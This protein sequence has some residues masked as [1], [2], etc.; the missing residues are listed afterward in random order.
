MAKS[1][2]SKKP[3]CDGKRVFIEVTGGDL[4]ETSQLFAFFDSSDKG[5]VDAIKPIE[6]LDLYNKKSIFSWDWCKQTAARNVQLVVKSEGEDILLPL[7]DEIQ[8]LTRKD[9]VQDYQLSAIVPLV[10][11]STDQSQPQ[12]APVRNGYIYIYY[13]EQIWRELEVSNNEGALTFKDVNLNTYRDVSNGL[14]TDKDRQATGLPLDAIFIPTRAKNTELTVKIAYSENAWSGSHINYIEANRSFCTERFSTIRQKKLITAKDLPEVRHRQPGIEWH[15][16]KPSF[17]NQDLTGKKVIDEEKNTQQCEAEL[18]DSPKAINDLVKNTSQREYGL[19]SRALYDILSRK[20]KASTLDIK[21]AS[22]CLASAKAHHYLGYVL[23]D[24]IFEVRHCL[25]QI[26]A[27]KEYL[28]LLLLDIEAQPYFRA[29][30]AVN[31]TVT[32]PKRSDG[33]GNYYHEFFDSMDNSPSGVFNRTL[34]TTEREL[35]RKD[36]EAIQHRLMNLLNSPHFQA[37][38]RGITSLDKLNGAGGLILGYQAINL[39]GTMIDK[40]DPHQMVPHKDAQ[41]NFRMFALSLMNEKNAHPIYPVL[42]MSSDDVDIT[43]GDYETPASPINDGSGLATPLNRSAMLPNLNEIAPDSVKQVD[44]ALYLATEDVER[45]NNT[46]FGDIR[47]MTGFVG[48]IL[49]SL[50][51]VM[52]E[53]KSSSV[54]LA[55]FD[56]GW[57]TPAMA[58]FIRELKSG[59]KEFSSVIFTDKYNVSKEFTVIGFESANVPRIGTI[60][61]NT[62]TITKSGTVT[63]SDAGDVIVGSKKL[64][65][66]S[67]KTKAVKMAL[68]PSDSKLS[69][70]L[71]NYPLLGKQAMSDTNSKG[72]TVSN[73]HAKLR[74]PLFLTGIE[75]WNLRNALMASNFD[76]NFAYSFTSILSALW[77]LST[78][79]VE[80][81]NSQFKKGVGKKIIVKASQEASKRLEKAIGYTLK[82]VSKLNATVAFGGYLTTAIWA[83]DSKN[84]FSV[85]DK[86]AGSAAAVAALGTAML[87]TEGTFLAATGGL[88]GF[89]PIGWL[90]VVLM[91]GGGLAYTLLKDTPIEAWLANGPFGKDDTFEGK[92]HAL[93]DPDTAYRYWVN[94]LIGPYISIVPFY[95]VSGLT[96]SDKAGLMAKNVTH[97]IV[98]STDMPILLTPK[99]VN[100]F[101]R[102]VINQ[103]TIHHKTGINTTTTQMTQSNA[104]VVE[105]R[106][107]S[108]HVIYFMSHPKAGRQAKT[109]YLVQTFYE[110]T[111]TVRV[112]LLLTDST[113]FPL[114]ALKKNNSP[115]W[116]A[117]DATPQFTDITDTSEPTWAD[118][119]HYRGKSN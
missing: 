53:I 32:P 21:E 115:V 19:K 105:S 58:T 64:S 46:F 66:A 27:A 87:A 16:T 68:V 2:L 84:A 116:G 61:S 107:M 22:D 24:I 7:F 59:A 15:L 97:A 35:L 67:N 77:D 31:V 13:N 76:N 93:S 86:D 63:F 100:F 49:S 91:L 71:K 55:D 96:P 8:S 18:R 44:L 50:Y 52:G 103:T 95:K 62:N 90:G 108:N 98:V 17:L 54:T 28:Q 45:K 82:D 29:A 102:E 119:K 73:A 14:I 43:T 36:C 5:K 3:A 88:L 110:A 12:V 60:S 69:K 26:S 70:I 23:D 20:K 117:S 75:I 42:F 6:Q 34:R 48:G 83:W 10:D 81:Y 109:S 118:E 4:S 80:A 1:K 114:E 72:L 112:Q 74:L 38:L 47:R 33:E 56:T 89:G 57:A 65:K 85:N 78:V 92:Y 41:V 9:D 37:A 30:Q 106:V 99:K 39:V 79:G 113:I 51:G 111:Y 94:L 40:L 104:P 101:A 11:L 25:H